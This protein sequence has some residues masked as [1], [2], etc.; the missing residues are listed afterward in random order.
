MSSPL[1]IISTPMEVYTAPVGEAFPAINEEPAG[2]W[3]LLGRNGKENRSDDGVVVTQPQDFF[4]VTVDGLTVPVKVFR[5]SESLMV[6]FTLYDLTMETYART[7]NGNA[8][9]DVAAAAGQAGNRSVSLYRGLRVTLYSVL[10]RGK[11]SPEQDDRNLQYEI[12]KAYMAGQTEVAFRKGDAAGLA[13][14][15]MALYDR[16]RP[17]GSELT[18]VRYQDE[19]PTA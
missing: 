17:A 5:T 12:A 6:A 2:N 18:A 15:W 16:S 3:S 7:V 14:E 10:V 9:T 11:A 4:E 19:D 8:I 1:E 13:F